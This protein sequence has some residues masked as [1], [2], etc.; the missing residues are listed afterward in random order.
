[1]HQ[2]WETTASMGRR[3]EQ[4]LA[5]KKKAEKENPFKKGQF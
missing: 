4:G 3:E 5:Q 1:M 2:I